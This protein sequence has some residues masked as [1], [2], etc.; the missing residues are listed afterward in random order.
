MFILGVTVSHSITCPSQLGGKISA[1]ERAEGGA[2]VG[3][4]VIYKVCVRCE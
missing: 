3:G 4:A 1:N 2:E